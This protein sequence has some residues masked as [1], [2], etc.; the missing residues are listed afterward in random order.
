MIKE[1]IEK[2]LDAMQKNNTNA[3][4]INKPEDRYY[5]SGFSGSNAFLLYTS[6]NTYLITDFRYIEQAKDE[7][8]DYQVVRY[9]RDDLYE[10]INDLL[11]KESINQLTFDSSAITYEMFQEMSEKL[12]VTLKSEKS[13]VKDIR[14]IKDEEEIATIKK[15][16][17]ISEKAFEQL[18]SIIK[19]GITEREL[20]VELEYNMLKLGASKLAFPSIVA[21]GVR[22]ALPH[23]RATDKVVEHGDFITFDFGAY[24][25]GYCSDMT[26]TIVVAECSNKQK[27]VYNTVLKAQ[28]EALAAIKVG[29]NGKDLDNVAREVITKAGYGEYF[30]HGLGHGVGKVVH[31]APS[32]SPLSKDILQE[33]QL[34]T[35]EPGIYI[36]NWGGVRIEDLVVIKE[37]GHINL[38]KFTKDLLVI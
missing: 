35:I 32:A 17:S 20:S 4:F 15:A 36:P 24:Y 3:L 1:R 2:L 25:N 21:S 29:V 34:L 16:Q 38:N 11:A 37:D 31:E 10:I 27:E 28:L 33:N 14:S 30:G 19:P 18:L 6:E 12:K 23:G 26:R 5:L 13:L 8:P 9:N 7:S 22:S